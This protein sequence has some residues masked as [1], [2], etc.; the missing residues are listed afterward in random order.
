MLNSMKKKIVVYLLSFSLV[1]SCRMKN[2]ADAI[3]YAS[4]FISENGESLQ[5]IRTTLN[6]SVDSFQ[7]KVI[8]TTEKPGS[9]VLHLNCNLCMNSVSKE[10]KA[11]VVNFINGTKTSYLAFKKSSYLE[12]GFYFRNHSFNQYFIREYNSLSDTIF[13][14]ESH[15]KQYHLKDNWV[16]CSNLREN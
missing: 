6:Q 5:F 14:T 11:R 10:E 3:N 7:Q 13:Y 16:L 8:I 12:V 15:F 9:E 1:C 2:E 4:N